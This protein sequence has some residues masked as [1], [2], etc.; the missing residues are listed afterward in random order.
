MA[1][2]PET[3]LV[4]AV[5]K[6]GEIGPA[7]QA[8]IVPDELK[9]HQHE[10][11]WLLDTYEKI[12]HVPDAEAFRAK[13]PNFLMV[14]TT[15]VAAHTLAVNDACNRSKMIKVTNAA[16]DL[17]AG[18]HIDEA[19]Q[20][21]SAE[22]MSIQTSMVEVNDSVDV[23]SEWPELFDLVEEKVDRVRQFGQ[24]GIPTGWSILDK[25]TGG[26]QDGWLVIVG[27]RS[28]NGK[29]FTMLRMAAEAAVAGKT[30]LYFS[31]EQSRHQIAMRSQSI[32]A[33]LIGAPE[34]NALDMMKGTVANTEQMR[35]AMRMIEVG[36]EGK[37]LVNDTSRGKVGTMQIAA[38]VERH[39]PDVVYVDYI[40]LL[41]MEGEGDWKS[42]AKLSA[43]LKR[44]GERYEIP[45]VAGS[46]T[47]RV[48][49]NGELP[50]VE[51]LSQADAI[52]HDSDL[53]ITLV[54]PVA[55]APVLK[56]GLKKNRHGP[57]GMEWFSEF[58]PGSGV[59]R[60]ISGGDADGLIQRSREQA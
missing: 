1:A 55:G 37:L 30:A 13:W 45:V 57:D 12:G 39:K 23:V 50:L 38:A 28:G 25:N 56:Y 29:T 7:L 35:A 10:W 51:H 49:A 3:L 19:I 2:H 9:I 53:I 41:S 31:L 54:R 22:L 14:E 33:N 16:I 36:V 11:E 48:S 21:V 44:I 26:L 8:Q 46:Q 40:T 42:V 20:M 59:M 52:G 27:A 24:A 18:G 34:I 15:D 60:E 5:V 47:N 17:L 4:S 32:L 6:S 58:R 43:D